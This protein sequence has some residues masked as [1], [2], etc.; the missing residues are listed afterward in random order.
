MQQWITDGAEKDKAPGGWVKAVVD[1]IMYR[2][3][4]G[5]KESEYIDEDF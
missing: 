4:D 2:R 1:G 3:P 5:S